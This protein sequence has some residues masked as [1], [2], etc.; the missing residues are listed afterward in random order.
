MTQIINPTNTGW[1][2]KWHPFQLRQYD[3]I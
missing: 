1:T 2:K 3:A